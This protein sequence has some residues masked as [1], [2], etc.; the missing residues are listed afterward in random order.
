MNNASGT[1]VEIG[2][3]DL[4]PFIEMKEILLKVAH[5]PF[6]SR[7]FFHKPGRSTHG[8]GLKFEISLCSKFQ[9]EGD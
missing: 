2:K 4:R 8:L 9:P 5:R 3:T 7:F 1:F 6:P